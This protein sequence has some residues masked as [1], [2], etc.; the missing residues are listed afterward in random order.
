MIKIQTLKK[1]EGSQE[2]FLFSLE[3]TVNSEPGFLP[4]WTEP[5]CF[6]RASKSR[7]EVRM[8]NF[9]LMFSLKYRKDEK[10]YLCVFDYGKNPETED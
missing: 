7:V 1:G 6:V 5:P 9:L 2:P 4:I 3:M 10:L 8:F